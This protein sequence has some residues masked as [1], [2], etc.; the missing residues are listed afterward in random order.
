MENK[1]IR[2]I[3]SDKADLVFEEMVNKFNLE[4]TE[5]SAKRITEGKSTKP[6]ILS[7]IISD[8]KKG[9][10]SEKDLPKTLQEKLEIPPPTSEELSKG[11]NSIL[12]L[13]EV[14]PEEKFN[15][16]TKE[17]ISE[18]P[19]TKTPAISKTK[20]AL[21]KKPPIELGNKSKA[22]EQITQDDTKSLKDPLETLRPK[23]VPPKKSI[24]PPKPIK[25]K[26]TGSDK[27]RESLE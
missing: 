19:E 1:N 23:K 15:Q 7:R 17:E 21:Y 2:V 26:T 22:T 13:L 14:S 27:Y 4:N 11:I 16:P 9:I 5:E 25:P 18:K 8:V 20:E 6:V 24:Q 12:P 10:V 3:F